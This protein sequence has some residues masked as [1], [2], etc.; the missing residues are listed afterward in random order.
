MNIIYPKNKYAVA[1]PG[2]GAQKQNMGMDLLDHCKE[3]FTLS[4]K[5]YP[6]FKSILQKSDSELSST[7]YSQPALYTV[8]AA[9]W[10]VMN[11]ITNPAYLAGHSVGEYVACYASGCFSF[12]DGLRLIKLR[13]ELMS[14]CS[15]TMFACI[16]SFDDVE[17]FVTHISANLGFVCEIANYNHDSQ[18]VISCDEKAVESINN[19]YRDFGIK[20]CIQLKVSGGFHSSLVSNVKDQ[21]ADEISKISFSTPRIPIISNKTGVATSDP[22]EV[23]SNL[24]D[25]VVSG[26]KWKNT[27]DYMKNHNVDML[28]EMGPGNVLSK[29]AEK[30]DI[31]SV[32]IRNIDDIMSMKKEFINV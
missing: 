3:I 2:Q 13:S 5:V 23:K 11:D 1:F 7:I 26:V 17:K 28:I 31:K 32:T 9:I 15:G 8:S 30:S 24:I 4:E 18:V 20:R 14:K 12:E 29:L 19:D 6:D 22:Q 16:G 10:S 25:H 21:L 27:M